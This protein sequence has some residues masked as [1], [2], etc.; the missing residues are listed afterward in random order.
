MAD[1]AREMNFY[2]EYEPLLGPKS[3]VR[4]ERRSSLDKAGPA[5]CYAWGLVPLCYIVEALSRGGFG[6]D[7]RLEPAISVLLGAQRESGGW[8]RNLGGHPNCTLPVLRALGAC[9][10]PPLADH[11]ERALEFMGGS[12][13]ETSLFSALHA[14][15][16]FSS[17]TART[18]IRSML[19]KAG[20]RQQ[21]NGTFGRPCQIERVAA[22]L[23]AMQSL[24]KAEE[25][26]NPVAR[27]G[28]GT[29]RPRDPGG[30][31]KA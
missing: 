23:R 19:A 2:R 14:V 18:L 5:S 9:P 29:R 11:V 22:V 30:S 13:Q 7:P 26:P 27:T 16:P 17:P 3:P 31:G 25:K 15:A 1:G 6:G 8:C 28:K 4:P 12:W 20:Q 24:E 21:R 10:R